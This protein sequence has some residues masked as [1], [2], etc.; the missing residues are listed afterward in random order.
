MSSGVNVNSAMEPEELQ[1]ALAAFPVVTFV[2]VPW[3]D[4]PACQ[5]CLSCD[6]LGG[7]DSTAVI[8]S[9]RFLG[10]TVDG[11]PVYSHTVRMPVSSCCLSWELKTAIRHGNDVTVEVLMMPKEVV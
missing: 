3:T 8:V 11:R 4:L 1:E 9:R 2:P 6:P 5:G 10:E 7:C